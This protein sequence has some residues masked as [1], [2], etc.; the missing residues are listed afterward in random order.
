MQGLSP[1]A[2]CFEVGIEPSR[3]STCEGKRQRSHRYG[4]AN[5]EAPTEAALLCSLTRANAGSWVGVGVIYGE[6]GP[7][8]YRFL[9][10]E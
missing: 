2:A 4:A 5:E 9:D 1:S 8:V 7:R 6:Q 3:N 10:R